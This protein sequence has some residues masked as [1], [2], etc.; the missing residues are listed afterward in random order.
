MWGGEKLKLAPSEALP[1]NETSVRR[2]AAQRGE[3][4]TRRRGGAPTSSAFPLTISCRNCHS[5][6]G[7]HS[8]VFLVVNVQVCG[9][10]SL[11]SF[12]FSHSLHP[13]CCLQDKNGI[14]VRRRSRSRDD[15][16][17]WKT[18]AWQCKKKKKKPVCVSWM[19]ISRHV[20]TST[21][22][23]EAVTCVQHTYSIY[24]FIQTVACRKIKV[25]I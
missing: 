7:Q 21:G 9:L 2:Q 3:N 11:L 24:I 5:W 4:V 6:S 17:T 18:V 12:S 1:F 25:R 8:F 19:C 13:E 16:G 23:M 14:V 20:A 15:V 10:K 22:R